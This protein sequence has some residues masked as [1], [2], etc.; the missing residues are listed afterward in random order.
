M[1][2]PNHVGI[3]YAIVYYASL[4]V[5]IKALDLKRRVVNAL[6]MQKQQYRQMAPALVLH[7]VV[8]KAFLT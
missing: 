6:K 4:R 8:K 2:V 5:L 3:G 1:A 7:L